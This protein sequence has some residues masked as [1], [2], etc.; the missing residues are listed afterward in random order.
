MRERAERMALRPVG[1]R[2]LLEI[3]LERKIAAL[4]SPAG[5]STLYYSNTTMLDRGSRDAGAGRSATREESCLLSYFGPRA[6]PK[7]GVTIGR[8]ELPP[9]EGRSRITIRACSRSHRRTRPQSTDWVDSE[10]VVS[11]L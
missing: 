9:G 11:W 5:A 6:V 8:L 7:E 3:E 4:I 2:H 10:L 1:C